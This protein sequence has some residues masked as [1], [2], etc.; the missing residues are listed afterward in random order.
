MFNIGGYLEAKKLCWWNTV[1]LT[2]L[3]LS[4]ER[5]VISPMQQLL[6]SMETMLSLFF[7]PVFSSSL[8]GEKAVRGKRRK[9][10]SLKE[11]RVA[12]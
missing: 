5:P 12:L 11:E 8:C 2:G 4:V 1:N 9:W 7:F 6:V 10:K 3:F